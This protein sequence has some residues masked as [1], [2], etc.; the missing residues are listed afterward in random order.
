MKVT[1][2]QL[3]NAIFII[4]ILVVLFTPI[5]FH[6]KVFFNKVVSLSPNELDENEQHKLTDY[7]WRLVTSDG[8]PFEF[9]EAKG[10]VVLV[11]FWATW[12]PPCVAEMPSLQKLY[13][14]YGDRVAF[15]FVAHDEQQKVLDFIRK[16]H[17]D[18]PVYFENGKAPEQ[19]KTSSIPT[20]FL[21]DGDGKI[22]IMKVGSA[23]W[24][25][26]TVRNLLDSLLNN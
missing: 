20:T 16:E 24:N 19:L 8:N 25:S 1:K 15:V 11:N 14:E 12:C 18:F 13:T 7:N 23:D 4:A 5:G 10:K 26:T 9:S 21:L 22:R 2:K 3:S 6:L 17:F